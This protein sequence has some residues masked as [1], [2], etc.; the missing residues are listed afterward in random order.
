MDSLKN[1]LSSPQRRKPLVDL[2]GSNTDLP[3]SPT[4][5]L[6]LLT[7]V[8][9][10][11]DFVEN[12]TNNSKLGHPIQLADISIASSLEN[13]IRRSIMQTPNKI[14]TYDCDAY[15]SECD[16]DQP[17]CSKYVRKFKSLGF[18]CDK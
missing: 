18:L 8:A 12:S 17:F 16:H 7:K 15:S 2:N 1:T 6:K 4:A 9:S 3:V 5:N 14:I 10:Q 11:C 13:E